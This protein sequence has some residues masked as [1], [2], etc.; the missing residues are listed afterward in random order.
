[1]ELRIVTAPEAL[2]LLQDG[3]PTRAVSLVGDDLRFPLASFG[4][5]HLILRFHDLEEE[6]EGF[7]APTEEQ[8]REA[9]A[10]TKDVTAGERLLVHCHA[11]KSRSPALAIGILVQA[12]LPPA[13][14]FEEVRALRPELIP[15]RLMVRQLDRIL[16]LK[17]ALVRVVDEHYRSLGPEGL[18]PIAVD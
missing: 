2:V 12:G 14:A 10:H 8:M 9:L 18:C 15:N 7:I 11:G 17:G 4:D 6:V 3:W 13:A 16:D 1:M 5:H